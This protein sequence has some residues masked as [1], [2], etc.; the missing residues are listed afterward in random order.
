MVPLIAHWLRCGE[1]LMAEPVANLPRPLQP[2]PRSER[3]I[4][5]AAGRGRA[6]LNFSVRAPARWADRAF[7]GS[8]LFVRGQHTAPSPRTSESPEVG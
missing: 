3:T 7:A 4:A 5:D 6:T 8:H 2:S 1:N